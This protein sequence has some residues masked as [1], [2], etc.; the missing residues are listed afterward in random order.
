MPL[1]RAVCYHLRF[2]TDRNQWRDYWGTAKILARQTAKAACNVRLNGPDGHKAKPNTWL[3]GALPATMV[4]TPVTGEVLLRC[5]A[6]AEE[7]ILSA[8]GLAGVVPSRGGPWSGSHLSGANQRMAAKVL[9]AVA[10]ASSAQGGR[11]AVKRLADDLPWEEPLRWHL[12]DRDRKAA[13]AT[14]TG[15]PVALQSARRRR[16][17]SSGSTG[18]SRRAKLLKLKKLQAGSPTERKMHRGCNAAANIRRE[19]AARAVRRSGPSG[20]SGVRKRPAAA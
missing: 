13:A 18:H 15:R 4:I 14:P 9:A 8:K 19:D 10:T 5:D 16:S 12:E 6:L 11:E 20:R 3:S 17:G 7:A 2:K 1:R